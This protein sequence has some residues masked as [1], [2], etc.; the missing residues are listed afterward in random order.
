MVVVGLLTTGILTR[1]LGV[2]G[3]GDLLLIQALLLVAQSVSNMGTGVIG[4]RELSRKRSKEKL[5]SLVVLRK[6]L[7]V[8]AVAG[9][10]VFS[11]VWSPLSAI[12]LPILVGG[13]MLILS[14]FLGDLGI[15]FQ[16]DLKMGWK[17]L[18]EVLIPVLIFVG[19]LIFGDEISLLGVMMI[20]FLARGIVFWVGR[21]LVGRD[22]GMMFGFWKGINWGLV[23]K[24]FLMSW[25]MGLY[26]LVFTSYDKMIDSLMI[27][28]FVGREGVA[29]YGLAYKIYGNLVMPA[30][31]LVS[32]VFPLLSKKERNKD[33][34]KKGLIVLLGMVV[35][36]LPVVW[37]GAGWAMKMLGGGGFDAGV[38]VL[39]ILGLALGFSYMNHMFGFLL[40]ARNGQKKMLVLGL[41]AVVFNLILNF[42]VIPIWGIEGA[43][44]VTVATEGL[45]TGFLVLALKRI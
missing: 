44:W 5:L 1:K 32:S 13:G 22:W 2:A 30:Y 36:G 39:K 15:A 45:M 11:F 35:I 34:V 18:L 21:K 19:L 33:L 23:K 26:L 25:P 3:Y 28:H 29:W 17:S 12:R 24:I 4:V 37:V 8:V 31:F 42:F 10:V 6:V 43:G 41:V 7:S 40:V 38:R 16:V 14:S 27:R 20:Y 9:L